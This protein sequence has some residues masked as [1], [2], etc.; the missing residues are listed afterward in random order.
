MIKDFESFKSFFKDYFR[1]TDFENEHKNYLIPDADDF[2]IVNSLE[3]ISRY[4]NDLSDSSQTSIA[5]NDLDKADWAISFIINGL[6]DNSNFALAGF[7]SKKTVPCHLSLV[8]S[9]FNYLFFG[10]DEECFFLVQHVRNVCLIFPHKLII[11][12]FEFAQG[13]AQPAAKEFEKIFD[14]LNKSKGRK[15]SFGGTFIGACIAQRRPYHYFYDYCHGLDVLDSFGINEL[16]IYGSDSTSFLEDDYFS[17]FKSYQSKSNDYMNNIC[18]EKISFM[19]VPCLPHYYS[20]Y[21][22][23]LSK[24]SIRLINYANSF[25]KK[26]SKECELKNLKLVIWVSVSS[27]KRTWI[28]EIDGLSSIINS[29]NKIYGKIGVLVDGRTFPILPNEIDF[30]C[31]VQEDKKFQSLTLLCPEVKFVNMIG[32]KSAEKILLASKCDFFISHAATDSMYPSAICGKPGVVY[33]ARS[34]GNDSKRFHLHPNIVELDQDKITDVFH[35][36]SLNEWSYISVSFD[37]HHLYDCVL[38]LI[39]RENLTLNLVS[40]Q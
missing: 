36:G 8:I 11:I 39:K 14:L 34:T 2:E 35:Q 24:L 22:R 33:S 19:V 31:K 32:L 29:L 12:A 20:S 21:D 27:E 5:L 6:K 26:S 13:W 25:I 1:S 38:D 17:N 15:V 23:S 3:F 30:D 10:N 7:F 28:E 9:D 37:W 4:F 40:P 18:L 16:D